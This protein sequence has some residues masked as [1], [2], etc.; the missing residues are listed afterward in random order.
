MTTPTTTPPP[1]SAL[2]TL[3]SSSGAKTPSDALPLEIL[4]NLRYQHHWTD[5]K[6]DLVCLNVN[7]NANVNVNVNATLISGFPPRHSYIHPDLQNYLVKHSMTD[8]AIPV[9]REWVLPL[10]LGEKWTLARFCALFDRLPEREVVVV[11]GNTGGS[12]SGSGSGSGGPGVY[13]HRDQK[14]VLLGM[15]ANEGGGGDGT[16]VY[17]IM[18]EGQVKPRQNG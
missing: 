4:H 1:P 9:Q 16:V 7:V 11:R 17:Y 15:R 12:G 3:L 14:R 6:R 18:Q 13:Q 2:S 5:L 8:S 10:S